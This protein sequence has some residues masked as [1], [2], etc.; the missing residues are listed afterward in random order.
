MITYTG[1]APGLLFIL[2]LCIVFFVVCC[3]VFYAYS[4]IIYGCYVWFVC[5]SLWGLYLD[6]LVAFTYCFCGVLGFWG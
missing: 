5:V 6:V 4:F 3:V 2:C 1:G